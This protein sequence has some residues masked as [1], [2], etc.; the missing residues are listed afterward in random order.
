[1]AETAEETGGA[2]GASE[3]GDRAAEFADPT[4]KTPAE[5]TNERT[6]RLG[7]RRKIILRR[8]GGIKAEAQQGGNGDVRALAASVVTLIDLLAELFSDQCG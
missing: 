8:L 4:P 3:P 7:E 6:D 5:L 2:V 1:L